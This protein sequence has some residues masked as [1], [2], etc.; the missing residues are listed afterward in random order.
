MRYS[1]SNPI[2]LEADYPYVAQDGVCNYDKSKGA[3]SAKSYSS[4]TANDSA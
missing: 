2:E 3:V 1:E 4:V